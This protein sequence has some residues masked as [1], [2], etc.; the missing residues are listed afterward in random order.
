MTIAD[1]F[2]T[3]IF[4]SLMASLVSGGAL[5]MIALPPLILV[6]CPLVGLCAVARRSSALQ[7]LHAACIIASI[8]PTVIGA[9]FALA[10]SGPYLDTGLNEPLAIVVRKYSSFVSSISICGTISVHADLLHFKLTVASPTYW[11]QALRIAR[12]TGAHSA[13]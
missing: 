13:S 11:Y 7:R 3:A 5:V 12:R 8:V 6:I 1:L 10:N 9:A 4:I 2:L